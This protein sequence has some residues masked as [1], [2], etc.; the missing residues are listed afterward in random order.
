MHISTFSKI[1]RERSD[2]DFPSCS[3]W[4]TSDWMNALHGETGE[5]ANILKKARRG[6]FGPRQTT[7]SEFTDKFGKELADALCYLDLAAASVGLSLEDVL[8]GKWNDVSRRINSSLFINPVTG[9]SEFSPDSSINRIVVLGVVAKPG[10]NLQAQ[11]L[12]EGMI[13]RYDSGPTALAKLHSPHAGGWQTYQCIDGMIYISSSAAGRL[14]IAP[15]EWDI[16][17]WYEVQMERASR[18]RRTRQDR[19]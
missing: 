9:Q 12:Q 17:K 7:S 13:V 3:D 6:D 15:T 8:I 5:A 16:R 19:A 10:F 11:H 4:T 18:N 14:L 2:I 1:N